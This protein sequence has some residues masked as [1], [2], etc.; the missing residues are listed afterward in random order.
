MS[1]L[2]NGVKSPAGVAAVPVVSFSEPQPTSLGAWSTAAAHSSISWPTSVSPP[3]APQSLQ[4]LAPISPGGS[5][6]HGGYGAPGFATD[7][8]QPG[9]LQHYPPPQP[10]EYLPVLGEYPPPPPQQHHRA[11]QPGSPG[12]SPSPQ[13]HYRDA[14]S[15]SPP[16]P[17]DQPT[18]WNPQASL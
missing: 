2:L 17:Q 12:S 15:D 7:L 4:P 8:Y 16:S 13:L 11:E 3:P 9:L 18:C 14:C 6:P 1:R 10:Q 5:S